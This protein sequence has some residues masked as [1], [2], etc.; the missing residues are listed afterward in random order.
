MGRREFTLQMWRGKKPE[1]SIVPAPDSF[2]PAV[3][4]ESVATSPRW[5][6][7]KCLMAWG[8]YGPTTA[9][10]RPQGNGCGECRDARWIADCP[11]SRIIDQRANIADHAAY[12]ELHPAA[13]LVMAIVERTI[14]RGR[15]HRLATSCHG[16]IEQ[17]VR[18]AV[19]E[20]MKRWAA[21]NRPSR[22]LLFPTVQ[23]TMNTMTVTCGFNDH[24]IGLGNVESFSVRYRWV[25]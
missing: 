24:A 8:V 14:E 18:P 4:V 1:P 16:P 6:C 15:W 21:E 12:Q 13:P 10:A 22:R 19:N 5:R 25:Q 11:Q 7:S 20:V 3:R 2:E 9:D 23:F 17:K